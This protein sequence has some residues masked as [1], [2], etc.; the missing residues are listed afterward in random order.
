MLMF[1]STMAGKK[2]L[3]RMPSIETKPQS[4]VTCTSRSIETFKATVSTI[5]Y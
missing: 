5:K 2:L 4:I 3:F 1:F